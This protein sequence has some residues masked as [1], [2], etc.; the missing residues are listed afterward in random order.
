MAQENF[1][2]FLPL[3]FTGVLPQD[4]RDQLWRAVADIARNLFHGLFRAPNLAQH[5]VYGMHQIHF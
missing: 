1:K 4:A 3:F 2:P 5:G